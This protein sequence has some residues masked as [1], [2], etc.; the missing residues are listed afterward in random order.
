M[1]FFSLIADVMLVSLLWL[2][3]S[4]LIITIG[5][6]TTASYYVLM[7]RISNRESSVLKDY[8]SSF[9]RNIKQAT[10]AFVI[11]VAC[12]L[13]NLYNLLFNPVSGSFGIIIYGLQIIFAIELVFLYINIFPIIARFDLKF[14]ELLKITLIIANRHLFITITHCALFIAIIWVCLNAPFLFIIAIG[15]Y[16][17][18]SSY[19][20][21]KVYRKYKPNMDKDIDSQIDIS[22]DKK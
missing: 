17:W 2:L 1:R 11:I 9:R 10:I 7:R 5:T 12:F 18:L 3:T 14:K 4:L 21:I 8:F 19:M 20:L 16:C 22:I 6:S 15:L 13:I